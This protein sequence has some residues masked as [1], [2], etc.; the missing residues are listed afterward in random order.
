MGTK[1]LFNSIAVFFSIIIFSSALHTTTLYAQAGKINGTVTDANGEVL[2]G[3]NIIID[4]T[5]QGASSSEDGFFQILNVKPG[6][7][8]LR[9]TYI[10]FASIVIENVNVAENL[11]TEVNFTL[12]EQTIE[13]EEIVVTAVQPVVRPDVSASVTSIQAQEIASLPVT[14]VA[15]VIGLGAGIRGTSVRGGSSSDL[16]F[17]VNG[18]S[19]RS[20]R[21]NSASQEISFTSLNSVQVQTGGFNAE[22]GNIQSGL[23]SVTTKEGDRE[24]YNMDVIFRLLPPQDKHFGPDIND[25]MA[26]P[27]L[28]PYL[29]PEVAFTGTGENFQEGAWDY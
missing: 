24:K 27:F 9:A 15:S 26:N 23:I 29:D 28:R 7:Y 19:Q 1:K 14:D 17:S 11:T 8:S 21:S 20:T 18:I 12:Q 10:G 16:E 3:V 6:I 13:G 5:L 25:P 22:Y 4:G 2:P